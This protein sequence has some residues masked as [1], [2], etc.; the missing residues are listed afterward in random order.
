[1]SCNALYSALYDALNCIPTPR[2]L[3]ILVSSAPAQCLSSLA[4]YT[5]NS[6][7]IIITP[8][9]TLH[10]HLENF[11]RKAVE[12]NQIVRNQISGFYCYFSS[13]ACI[14]PFTITK[15]QFQPRY[16]CSPSNPV[17][18]SGTIKCIFD[19]CRVR[20][21]RP[22][23]SVSSE[24][25]VSCWPKNEMEATEMFELTENKIEDLL[26][27]KHLSVVSEQD[28]LILQNIAEKMT[29]QKSG[30]L[31]QFE[32]HK[33]SMIPHEKNICAYFC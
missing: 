26:R 21:L 11:L 12:P 2:L 1:M 8:K 13:A 27:Q 30:I 32:L 19:N 23:Q 15:K 16:F 24:Y 6:T 22:T 10:P 31:I 29:K 7:V 20:F 25:A 3:F 17:V 9:S 33:I 5:R 28:K 18:W 14:P 4:S